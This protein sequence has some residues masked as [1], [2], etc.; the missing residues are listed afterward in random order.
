MTASLR[1]ESQWI[2]LENK[3]SFKEIRVSPAA[4]LFGASLKKALRLT[5]GLTFADTT[6]THRNF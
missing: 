1:A 6:V 4:A 2:F 3:M 5:S